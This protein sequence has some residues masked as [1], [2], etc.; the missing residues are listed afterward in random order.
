M[1]P[2]NNL[3]ALFVQIPIYTPFCYCRDARNA[4]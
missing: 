1:P 3:C 4:I 2:Q